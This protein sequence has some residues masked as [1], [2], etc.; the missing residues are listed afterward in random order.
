MNNQKPLRNCSM[1]FELCIIGLHL[2]YE[3]ITP[4]KIP[5]SLSKTHEVCEKRR[6]K[7]VIISFLP[8]LKQYLL[9]LISPFLLI[10]T[11][12][13]YD[14]YSNSKNQLCPQISPIGTFSTF[15]KASQHPSE[16]IRPTASTIST[17]CQQ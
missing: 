8:T 9:A 15:K 14:N 12:P 4:N 10:D 5:L 13:M 1:Q 3:N 6:H 2:N 17:H 7:Q 16:H 11:L